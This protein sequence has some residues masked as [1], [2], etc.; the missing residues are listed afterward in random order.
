MYVSLSLGKIEGKL[1]AAWIHTGNLQFMIT[2]G[3]GFSVVSGWFLSESLHAFI[4]D[5]CMSVFTI[6]PVVY[7]IQHFHGNDKSITNQCILLKS[8][9]QLTD[10]CYNSVCADVDFWLQLDKLPILSYR[11]IIFLESCEKLFWNTW[12]NN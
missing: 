2:V 1:N 6:A 9:S 7:Q 8:L 12:S 10:K 11:G 4:Y 3:T 5:N